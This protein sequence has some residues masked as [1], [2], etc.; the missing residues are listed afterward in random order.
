MGTSSPMPVILV[1]DDEPAN[2]AVL[3]GVLAS[4]GRV[5]AVTSGERA[6]RAAAGPPVPDLILL[7]V[8]MPV[9]DGYGV[10]AQLRTQPATRDI[11]VIFITAL[12]DAVDE[13][14]GLSLGAVDYLTKPVNPAIVMARVRAQLEI[15]AARD[16]LR[17]QNAWLEAEVRRRLR[18]N[19]LIQEVSLNALAG[20]AETRDTDIGN[21]IYRTQAYLEVLARG[22]AQDPRWTAALDGER[23][24]QIIKAAALHDLGKIGIPDHILLKPGPLTPGEFEVMKG[25]ARIGGTAIDRAIERCLAHQGAAWGPERPSALA[26]LEVASL[27]AT[28]HHERWDGTGYPDGLAGEAI[29]LPARIMAVAD[30]YDALTSPRTY[31]AAL[32]AEAAS[33]YI[34]SQESGQFDPSLVAVFREQQSCIAGIA[35]EFADRGPTDGPSYAA[36]RLPVT[37]GERVP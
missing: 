22:L 34:I 17:V 18:D 25:H 10:L 19:L 26:F 5:L 21:H 32:S 13:A 1:V 35:R 28:H 36:P 4:L 11:P 7:D 27:I 6:L 12:S 31:R 16:Q 23:L 2:L 24:D 9:L 37:A 3:S 15:K 30:V 14:H 8:M 20:L 33:D 29:P